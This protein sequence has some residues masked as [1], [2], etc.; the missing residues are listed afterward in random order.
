[1]SDCNCGIVVNARLF[2][3]PGAGLRGTRGGTFVQRRAGHGV[4]RSA[5]RPRCRPPFRAVPAPVGVFSGRAGHGS[6]QAPRGEAVTLR[7][8]QP[9]ARGPRGLRLPLGGTAFAADSNSGRAQP[10]L[11]APPPQA[12]IARCLQ[13]RSAMGPGQWSDNAVPVSCLGSHPYLG[14]AGS[15]G[16]HSSPQTPHAVPGPTPP[17]P[18]RDPAPAARSHPQAPHKSCARVAPRRA[19]AW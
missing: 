9:S 19:A 14:A 8:N 4:I 7:A 16:T 18:G 13:G 2:R 1:M 5:Q 11:C 10:M 12:Q 17:P 3:P 15:W 6:A